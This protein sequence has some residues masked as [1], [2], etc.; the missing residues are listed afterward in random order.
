MAETSPAAADVN[1]TNPSAMAVTNSSSGCFDFSL[2][3]EHTI[4]SLAPS[5]VFLV[6]ADVRLFTLLRRRKNKVV[7]TGRAFQSCKLFA[8][9]CYAAV[10][11]ALLVPWTRP[12]AYG[13][14][15]SLSAAVLG[16]LDVL[17]LAALSWLETPTRPA[18]RR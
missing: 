7:V 5:S 14:R 13:T 2:V 9:A 1:R 17:A 18:G 12:G 15:A 16:L 11:T 8:V 4:L 6:L 10:Q 3:F